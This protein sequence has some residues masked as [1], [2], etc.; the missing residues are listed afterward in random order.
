MEQCLGTNQFEEVMLEV[1]EKVA[2]INNQEML[3]DESIPFA[4]EITQIENKKT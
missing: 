2:K 1:K 4:C 3:A